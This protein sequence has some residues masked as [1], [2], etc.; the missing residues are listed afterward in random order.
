[1][2]SDH[3]RYFDSA[4]RWFGRRLEELDE[5]VRRAL[6]HASERRAISGDPSRCAVPSSFG[7]RLA[8]RVAQLGGSWTFIL[9]F[10]LLLVVWAGV[11]T[12]LLR[13]GA[14]DPYPYVFL[15]LLLSMIAALQAPVIMMSQNRQAAKDREMAAYDYEVNVKAEIEIMALHDKL[16][17]LR[18][19][20]LRELLARQ[21]AQLDLLTGLVAK[22][23]VPAGDTTPR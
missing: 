4:P 8:D 11:N 7:E 19:E 18:G 23:S 20:Q 16:D 2:S 9:L 21:Q 17:A 12:W 1:M 6:A 15:N 10:T 22:L 3:S 13:S 5:R 14:F